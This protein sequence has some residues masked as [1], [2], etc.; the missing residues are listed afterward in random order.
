MLSA[1]P[2]LL[3]Y[4]RFSSLLI[5]FILSIIFIAYA[6]RTF[7]DPEARIPQK[8]VGL[9]E[10]VAGVLLLIGLWTQVAALVII[11]DMVMCLIVK[12]RS[13]AFLSDGVNYYILLLVMAISLLI[14]GAGWL[15]FDLPL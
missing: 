13:R 7:R 1:F 14:T 8:F 9:I 5:R 11:V 4:S 15:A 10:G 12:F 6:Y 2:T 3:S